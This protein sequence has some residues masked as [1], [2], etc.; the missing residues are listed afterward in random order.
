MFRKISSSSLHTSTPTDWLTS[1][2]HFSFADYYNPK[3][4]NFG[5][6][7]VMN[8]D[9]VQPR[10]GFET[11]PHK[12][13]EIVTYIV[14]GNLTHQDSTGNKE[15]LGRGAVQYMSAGTGIFHSEKNDSKSDPVRFIQIWITPDVKNVKPNYGS[16]VYQDEE[17]KN[18]WLHLI[19][20]WKNAEANS[21]LIGF[22]QDANLYV[23]EMEKNKK[24]DFTLSEKRQAYV[25]CIEGKVSVNGKD[26]LEERDAME[27]KGNTNIEF[28]TKEEGGHLLL[29][30]MQQSE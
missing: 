11:H 7:R 26:T 25:L 24:L 15:T 22:H 27:V 28:E 30:E 17:R 6:L 8:D 10:S 4:T 20:N 3:N 5:V 23:S 1:R 12:N 9:I 13:M 19:S 21:N 2:F 16:K 18:K 14:K 29:I